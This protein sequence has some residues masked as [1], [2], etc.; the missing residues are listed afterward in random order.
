MLNALVAGRLICILDMAE[1]LSMGERFLVRFFIDWHQLKAA[2]AQ[3]GWMCFELPGGWYADIRE[4]ASCCQPA[5][6][7]SF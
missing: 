6:F 7:A 1:I 3:A 5:R 4:L 2:G